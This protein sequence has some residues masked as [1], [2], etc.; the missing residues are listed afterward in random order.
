MVENYR[1]TTFG[2]IQYET[3]ENTEIWNSSQLLKVTFPI[4]K[5]KTIQTTKGNMKRQKK[6]RNHTYINRKYISKAK[7]G[8]F[9]Y[10]SM[11]ENYVI[12]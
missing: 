7:R 1:E 10:S 2:K 3:W 5:S 6:E 11:I 9:L 4:R 12:E 8:V